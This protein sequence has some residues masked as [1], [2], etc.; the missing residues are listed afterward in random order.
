MGLEIAHT[1]E[2]YL[3]RRLHRVNHSQDPR[4]VREMLAI[5]RQS[6]HRKR[7]LST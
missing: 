3:K 7:A 6:I 4:S 5:H 2:V 1:E